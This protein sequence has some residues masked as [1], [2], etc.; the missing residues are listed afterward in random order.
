MAYDFAAYEH[1]QRFK[2]LFQHNASGKLGI[3]QYIAD[4][5]GSKLA[6]TKK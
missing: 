2:P 1:F 3:Y 5:N 6:R 4:N